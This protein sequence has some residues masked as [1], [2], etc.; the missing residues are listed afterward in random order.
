MSYRNSEGYC[1]P[2]AGAA[3]AQVRREEHR[4]AYRPLVYICSKRAPTGYFLSGLVKFRI[5]QNGCRFW[6]C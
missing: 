5:D 2:T 4:K 6:M 1:D 3:L